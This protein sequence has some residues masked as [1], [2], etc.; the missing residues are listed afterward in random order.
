MMATEDKLVEAAR[1]R[2]ADDSGDD[3]DRHRV[4]AAERQERMVTKEMPLDALTIVRKVTFNAQGDAEYMI[5]PAGAEMLNAWWDE[6]LDLA[7]GGVLVEDIGAVMGETR[8]ELRK[9][10]RAQIAD[11]ISKLT[12][13]VDA[14]MHFEMKEHERL[15]SVVEQMGRE[16]AEL[17][18]ELNVLRGTGSKRERRP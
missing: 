4:R 15:K 14:L 18:G 3:L 1:R 13:T 2:I 10:W 7:W 6:K 5:D 12:K 16:I 11:E 17:R 9:E 8:A